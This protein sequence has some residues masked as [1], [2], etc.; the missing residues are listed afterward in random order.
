MTT[1]ASVNVLVPV[2]ITDAMLTSS[3]IAEPAAG[4]TAWVSAGTYALG[5]LCIRTTTHRVYRCALAH[6]GRT[7]LPESDPVYWRDVYATQKWSMFDAYASTQ[8]SIATPL[9]VVIKPGFFNAFALLGLDGATAT[10]TY[11]ET[12]GGATSYSGTVSL[13]EDPLDWYDWAFGA[14]K[15]KSKLVI[16]NLTPFPDP[17]LTISITAATGTVKCGMLAVG[18]MRNLLDGADFGG[19]QY[20]AT[21]EPIT[22]SYIKTDEYGNTVIKRRSAATDMKIR[23]VLPR[24]SSD[25][26]LA[27][28]QAL[29]DVPA[30]WMASDQF[31]YAGL[32]AFGLGSGSLSYESFSHDI[33][34]INV[35]GMI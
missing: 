31:G 4:E 34:S 17:E 29:L 5:D 11:K 28:V 7:A 2:T 21:A 26:A 20:G 30:V 19:T 8:S 25:F 23:L 35:K 15:L 32:T 33:F 24:S 3:T 14:I 10:I 22:Y 12:T 27:T 18:D 1:T 13:Q 9:T 6:T 16:D